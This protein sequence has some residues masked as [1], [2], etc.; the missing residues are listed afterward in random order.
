MIS[1][2]TTAASVGAAG[3]PQ[4]GVV[5]MVMILDA[6]GLPPEDISLVIAVD[7]ILDRLRTIVNI[8]GDAFGA[9][10]VDH[11]CRAELSDDDPEEQ[12]VED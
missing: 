11:L 7:W 2:T 1:L 6:I 9:Q 8:L 5:T 10:V 4:A 12:P 3:I